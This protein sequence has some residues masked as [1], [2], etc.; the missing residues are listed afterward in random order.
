MFD[1]DGT[2]L[3]SEH[4][5]GQCYQQAIFEV[6]GQPLD[7][8]WTR[9]EHVSDSGI[10]DQHLRELG[11]ESGHDAIKADVKRLF[12]A[13]IARHL[14]REPAR[15]IAGAVEFIRRLRGIENSSL[16]IATGGWRETAL[17]KLASA[18]IDVD[19]LPLASASDHYSRI[20]IMKI[21]ATQAG[22]KLEQPWVYFGDGE[23]DQQA[24]AALGFDFVAV[25]HRISHKNQI[26]DFS[27]V[28]QAMSYLGR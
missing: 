6:L 12:S 1:I 4:F 26:A 14:E 8:D 5:D 21:A 18:S 23:W 2:L 19:G 28:A 20:E 27:D 3:Q 15:P 13:K 7:T 25:G 17:L 24:C 9:Y 16:C 22:G 10:L 11:L